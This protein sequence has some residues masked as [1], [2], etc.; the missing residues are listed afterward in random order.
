MLYWARKTDR[1]Q[2]K[3]HIDP[4]VKPV[5]QQAT[6]IPFSMRSKVE[7]KLQELLDLDVVEE[8]QGPT[9]WVS[10]IVIVPKSQNNIRLCIDMRQA[11]G[12]IIRER[13][14]IPT[15]D[16]VLH[17][18]NETVVFRKLDLKWGFHQIELME[19]SMAITTFSTHKGLYRYK[20]L[21]FGITSAPE[22]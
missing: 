22:M 1:F 15:I 13:F 14:P 12:A 19:D 6:R 10:P 5:A 21:M 8:V 7:A 18:L 2:A 9:S 11:N 3:I 4:E 16:E 17:D 20:R